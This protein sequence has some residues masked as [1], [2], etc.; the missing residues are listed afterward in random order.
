MGCTGNRIIHTPNVDA[1]ARSGT[2][3]R[4]MFVTTPIC[5][6]SRASILTGLYERT[7]HFTFNTAPISPA[8]LA[9]SYP[10]QLKAAGYHTGFI[11]KFGV[12]VPKGAEAGLFD[13]FEPLAHP[14]VRKMP[15]GSQ[16]WL[17]D[18]AGDDAVRFIEQ[19]PSDR[20]FCLSVSFNAPHAEDNTKEQYFWPDRLNGLYD[21]VTFHPPA[22]MSPEFFAAQP[23]FLQRSESRV[24][25]GWRFNEP[26]KYQR[27]VR[28]YYRMLTGVDEEVGRIREALKRRGVAENTIIVYTSDNGYFLG[29]RGFADKWYGYEHSLR[30]PLVIY[31]PRSP[32]KE[33]VQAA[34]ALNIDL[35]ATIL[36][37]AGLKGPSSYQGRSLRPPL[38]GKKPKEWRHDFFFE[39]LF[40]H[41]G[42]PKSEGTRNERYTYLRW[43]QQQPVVEE[44]YDHEKDFE[45]THNL[46]DVPRYRELLEEMRHR[47]DELRDHYGGPYRG[48]RLPDPGPSRQAIRA[49]YALS[50]SAR[51]AA[52][53]LASA[54]PPAH[55]PPASTAQPRTSGLSISPASYS[56]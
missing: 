46:V 6:A 3:F 7:H 8:D 41:P 52:E 32:R 33:Q 31:D 2:R 34:T 48:P 17:E 54:Q 10:A 27:M 19:S 45:E 11:G 5:A 42:I 24:R 35:P 55:F 36:D 20:P 26:E 22:T 56:R 16:R 53:L 49:G 25:Y 39:H 28:G 44:L 4:N 51:G 18:I 9:A 12:Q 30:V 13:S 21:N 1:L 47:T 15:D 40:E 29:E 37:F 23:A 50:F 43:F 38:N 14:Y